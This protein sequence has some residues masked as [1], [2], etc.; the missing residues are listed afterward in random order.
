MLQYWRR[1]YLAGTHLSTQNTYLMALKIYLKFVWPFFTRLQN[2]P[3]I[4]ILFGISAAGVKSPLMASEAKQSPEV[5]IL[6]SI[7][8]LELIGREVAGPYPFYRHST[9][10]PPGFTP[11]DY[12]LKI[13]DIKK[14]KQADIIVWMGKSIE[15]YLYRTIDKIK[16]QQP[17]KIIINLSADNKK[18]KIK[19][20]DINQEESHGH[21]HNEK[22]D[23][24]YASIEEVDPHF[25]LSPYNAIIVGQMLV[26]KISEKYPHMKKNLESGLNVFTG[27]L[28]VLASGEKKVTYKPYIVYHDAFAY[29]ENFLKIKNSGAISN[30][31]HEK[32][33]V[34][35]IVQISEIVEK[36]NINCMISPLSY[37]QRLV[38]KLFESK[39]IT[40]EKIDILAEISSKG[41]LYTDYIISIMKSLKACIH[42]E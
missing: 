16:T 36:N 4:L 37:D 9:L 34:R 22:H 27:N 29:L 41:T 35:T 8:P 24:Q 3:V 39:T 23:E 21:H 6:Y 19:W 28:K 10:L 11:H 14:M 7:R 38:D 12:A 17:E 25:W 18:S 42:Y 1:K 40:I 15:P 2:I 20:I 5:S 33:G 30:H 13:S 32:P 26:E 31:Q